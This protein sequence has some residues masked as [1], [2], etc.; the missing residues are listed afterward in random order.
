MSSPSR[1]LWG[2]DADIPPGEY[3]WIAAG[4]GVQGLPFVHVFGQ[5]EG[6]AEL[7]IDWG[8]DQTKANKR[9]FDRLQ[10]H[11]GEAEGASPVRSLAPRPP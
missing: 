10:E 6:G 7:Y 9:I 4:S 1:G 5:D 3:R 8:A 2:R 11:K